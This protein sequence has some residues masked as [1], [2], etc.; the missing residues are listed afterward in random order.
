MLR[1]PATNRRTMLWLMGS[2]LATVYLSVALPVEAVTRPLGRLP[3]SLGLLPLQNDL[4]RQARRRIQ[5]RPGN[6]R[7]YQAAQTYLRSPDNPVALDRFE[8][9]VRRDFVSGRVTVLDGWVV[10][11]TEVA[12]LASVKPR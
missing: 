6:R 3:G 2:A 12:L 7:L 9:H 10:S 11:E 8:H 5:A 4:L 1:S